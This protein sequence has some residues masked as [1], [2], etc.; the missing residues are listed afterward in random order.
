MAQGRSLLN[1]QLY[2]LTLLLTLCSGHVNVFYPSSV[3]TYNIRVLQTRQ[4][5]HFLERNTHTHDLFCTD[6]ARGPEQEEEISTV[7]VH[8][9]HTV[10]RDKRSAHT[11]VIL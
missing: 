10:Q 1:L 5:L 3:V 4:H 8:T 7:C 11:G 9:E 2:H 6:Q